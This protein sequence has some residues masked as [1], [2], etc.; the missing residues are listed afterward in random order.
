MPTLHLIYLP[1]LYAGVTEDETNNTTAAEIPTT[2]RIHHEQSR[3]P[4]DD[5]TRNASSNNKEPP[6][7]GGEKMKARSD[8][9]EEGDD[10]LDTLLQEAIDEVNRRSFGS[11][12]VR[13]QQVP[14][15]EEI[16]LSSDEEES[17]NESLLLEFVD[18]GVQQFQDE[19][20]SSDEEM[21]NDSTSSVNLDAIRQKSGNKRKRRAP[22]QSV[23]DRLNDLMAFKAKY[24][25]CDVSY[26]G[27]DA[28]LGQ[29]CT[30]LRGSY[31]K[32]QTNQEPKIKLSDEQIQLLNDVGF[33]WSLREKEITSI[34]RFDERFND[35]MAFKA[36]YGHC[37]VSQHGEDASLG[38]WC[39]I[40]RGSYKKMQ[41]NQ[42]PRTKLSDEKI[43]RLNDAGFKWCLHQGELMSKNRF[44]KRFDDLMAFKAKYGHCDVSKRGE[45]ASL[46]LWCNT[47]RRSYKKIQNNQKPITKLS[48]EQIQRLS[49]AG[50]KW[51]LRKVGSGFDKRFNDLMAFKAKYG[52]CDVSKR[53]E[54]ASLGQ[55]CRELRGSY[56][57]V[58]N[59]Q[60]PRTKLSDEQIQCLNDAGFKWCW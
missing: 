22:K 36:K 37:Y 50:F 16:V 14:H 56:K 10:Y 40:V 52:H 5:A 27:E 45:N 8:D 33:K 55:W 43:Q 20:V 2:P 46:G 48:D 59:N 28:S 41:N 17:E 53:G 15:G 13:N 18:A 29:W 60:K 30:G 47:V 49:D 35:L 57:K 24:G 38:Q 58:Q 1:E 4:I 34:K 54:D 25:H 23:D 12:A 7:A 3:F 32:I 39:N 9:H 21:E 19:M 6:A 26:T 11:H 51:S 31:K 42:K 44:D